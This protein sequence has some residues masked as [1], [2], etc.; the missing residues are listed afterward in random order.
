[1]I[2]NCSVSGSS[3]Q[4]RV[5][6]PG[7]VPEEVVEPATD[8]QGRT[9]W[10]AGGTCLTL[11][12]GAPV[13]FT[14]LPPSRPPV[15]TGDS[16]A[17]GVIRSHSSPVPSWCC[18]FRGKGRLRSVEVGVVCSGEKEETSDERV[19]VSFVQVLDGGNCLYL[20]LRVS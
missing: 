16:G 2:R 19:F 13:S 17:P 18:S 6:T 3:R 5:L 15:Q 14:T 10:G 11:G 12:V 8:Q 9:E 20:Y 7:V 4:K 1:M